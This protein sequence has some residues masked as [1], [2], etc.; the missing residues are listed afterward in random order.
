MNA[1]GETYAAWQE[2]NSGQTQWGFYVQKINSSGTRQWGDGIAVQSLGT[3]QV[4]IYTVMTKD[5]A[6][7]VCFNQDAGSGTNTIKAT[8]IGTSGAYL[9][10]GNIVTA[11][12]IT[13]SKIRLNSV[14]NSSGMSILSWQDKRNDG[15]GIYAQNIK[16]DGTFGP[17]TGVVNISSNTPDK[18]ALDQNYPNPFNPVTKIRYELASLSF[19]NIT[20]YNSLGAIVAELINDRQNAGIY[21]AGFDASNLA[22]GIYFYR[23]NAVSDNGQLFT[24]T[25]KMM[26]VK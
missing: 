8:K 26:L 13:S 20:V 17:L 22:S 23:I 9:W 5:T 4:G 15:G 19:V 18:F 3:N 7:I 14:V 16:A 10:S 12:S 11:S 24:D 6:A 25:K 21:E 2:A 1:T